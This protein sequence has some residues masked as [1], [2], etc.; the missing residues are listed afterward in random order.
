MRF[1]PL[2][3]ALLTLGALASPAAAEGEGR[4]SIT[5]TVD[6]ALGSSSAGDALGMLAP[7]GHF[8]LG[9]RVRRWRLA[10]ELDTALWSNPAAPKDHPESGSFTR[11]GVALRW[12]LMDLASPAGDQRPG[13]AYRIYVEGGL[14][15]QRVHAPG[16]TVARGDVM[17][18]LGVAP[19][20][21]FGRALF[22]ANFGVRALISEA[23]DDQIARTVCEACR[24]VT[25][26]DLTLMFV[27]GFTVGT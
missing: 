9:F 15:R 23:V 17:L 2:S 14:G 19:E 6:F 7:G 20:L 21:A 22:G 3:V 18:G 24:P 10:A 11:G 4:G 13:A 5:T 26:H 1:R 8:D 12:N 27:F 16:I 25:R